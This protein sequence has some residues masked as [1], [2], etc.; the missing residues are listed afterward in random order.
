MRITAFEM[1]A[2]G[3]PLARVEREL[4][5]PRAGEAVVAVKG[6]G[7]CHTDLGFLDD[8]VP[9]RHPLPLVLGHEVAGVV[10]GGIGLPDHLPPGTPVIV[11]AVIPCGA[12][13]PCRRGRGDIC[14]AQ[15]FPG[16]DDH[17]GFASA[18]VVPAHGLCP[19]GAVPPDSQDFA[20]LAVV[21]D[22]VSTAYAAVEKSGLRRED[23]ALFVGVGG[24]GGF[25][26]QIAKAAGAHV[27]AI[28]VDEGRLARLAECGIDFTLC[29]RGRD[30]RD[31]KKEVRD[32]AKSARL[33]ASE[34][35]V[36]ETSG[37]AA[38]Q[39]LAFHLLCHG[40]SLSVVGY[41]PGDVTVRLSNLMA[42]AAR[43][44]GTW[45]CA[46]DR[47]PAVL[48]LVLSGRVRLEPFVEIRPMST[49]N[50]V[51]AQLRD[52][53]LSRRPVLVPDF[54]PDTERPR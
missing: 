14:R 15:V 36:F 50:D 18:L 39:E 45:G 29:A 12:C 33:P 38:G 40:G 13:D 22:A 51:L 32:L 20:R 47:F 42:F 41:F 52:H 48:D 6:C 5:E 37:T 11:P 35:K 21:A 23:L 54:G 8:G 4:R 9:T 19:V 26:A 25:G 34:W 43:A 46:P 2:V 53:R 30:V 17:G 16:N 1:R 31:V 28:D 24:V 49:V 44:E 3:A 10:T 7:V 27:I